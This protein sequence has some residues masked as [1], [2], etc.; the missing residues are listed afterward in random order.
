MNHVGGRNGVARPPTSARRLGYEPAYVGGRAPSTG[1]REEHDPIIRRCRPLLGTFVEITAQW[2]AGLRP[3]ELNGDS[4]LHAAINRAFAAIERVQCLMSVH[5]DA[6]E[7]SQVNA[8]ALHRSV[9][10]SDETFSVLERGLEIAR[11]SA[12]AFD[13]TIAP[14]LARWGLLPANLRRRGHGN[15]RDIT[16]QR[17]NR[18]RFTRPLAIDLGGI[19]KGFAVDAAISS[20]RDSQVTSAVVNAGGDLRVFGADGILVHLRHPVTA[21]PLGNP[22]LLRDAALATSSPCFSR[23]Q[24][25]GRTISHLLNP[26]TRRPVTDSTSVSVRADECWLADALTKVVLNADTATATRLLQAHHAEAF[27][28]SA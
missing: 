20:L 1:S 4:Q 9:K 13:F 25:R 19:A 3:V 6:S 10:V 15:W 11:A 21:Q 5:D 22:L 16:L 17:G 7:I 18:V 26:G 8:E 14:V 12:G 27:V 24:Y 2:S 23:R 28:L